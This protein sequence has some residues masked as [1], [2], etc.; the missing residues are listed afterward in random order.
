[1][2]AA[3]RCLARVRFARFRSPLISAGYSVSGTIG[4]R[5]TRGQINFESGFGLIGTAMWC[6]HFPV[7]ESKIQVKH[8]GH[9]V[10]IR[11]YQ[12]HLDWD[13]VRVR[14]ILKKIVQFGPTTPVEDAFARFDVQKALRGGRGDS[15]EE[16]G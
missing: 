12:F 8:L 11:T 14:L 4:G 15:V 5:V 6:R 2:K 3:R 16:A 10:L 7:W 1:M 13:A 9:L